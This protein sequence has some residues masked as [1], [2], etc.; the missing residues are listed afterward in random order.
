MFL[1]HLLGSLSVVDFT[2]PAGVDVPARP[3]HQGHEEIAVVV[4]GRGRYHLAEGDIPARPGMVFW[5]CAGQAV[6]ATADRNQPFHVL[7][8]FFGARAPR[9]TDP[10]HFAWSSVQG[11]HDFVGQAHFFRDR[12]LLGDAEV[13]RGLYAHLENQRR[14]SQE[15][16]RAGSVPPVLSR[17]NAIIHREACRGLS[18][19]ALAAAV[20]L[21][22]SH[23]RKLFREHLRVT[24]GQAIRDARI[25]TAEHLLRTTTL[26]VKEITAHCGY[27]D[28]RAFL[29]TFRER[30]GQTPTVYR[31]AASTDGR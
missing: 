29:D 2:G 3:I 31:E 8:M 9:F 17:A 22:P 10:T 5:Y 18:V 16:A 30:T 13:V 25:T 11:C 6:K 4:G 1:D 14:M 20:R 15:L 24:P 12:D 7:V 26:S 28:Y 27:E 23:L 21:S 19:N